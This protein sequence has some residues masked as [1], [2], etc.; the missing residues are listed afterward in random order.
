MPRLR[1]I[2]LLPENFLGGKTRIA[3]YLAMHGHFAGVTSAAMLPRTVYDVLVASLL[4]ATEGLVKQLN[5][6]QPHRIS[7]YPSS[8]AML[9]D[10]ALH[11]TLRIHPQTLLVGGEVLTESMKQKIQEAWGAP[12]YEIYSASESIYLA[13]RTP[14][15]ENLQV[16]EP[17]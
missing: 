11:G 8:V 10:L 15:E 6:F 7:G 2:F 3:C 9:A 4:D 12:I 5:E 17:T 16:V 13:I 14:G 1:R